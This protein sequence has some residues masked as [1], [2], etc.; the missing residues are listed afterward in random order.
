MQI[1]KSNALIPSKP[2]NICSELHS[3]YYVL[4]SWDLC[5]VMY[6]FFFQIMLIKA[7][8]I[9]LRDLV[10]VGH[11][12][13]ILFWDPR[14]TWMFK[15]CSVVRSWGSWIIIFVSSRDPRDV[16]FLL[17][18]EIMGILDLDWAILSWD[19]VDLAFWYFIFVVSWFLPAAHV[20]LLQVY[21]LQVY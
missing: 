4:F 6:Y 1:Q 2:P 19:P 5:L 17:C 9:L 10:D 13:F 8:G 15:V 20:C 16:G 3:L 11:W 18:R 12:T 7:L 21:T 14:G